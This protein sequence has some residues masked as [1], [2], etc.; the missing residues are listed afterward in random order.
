MTSQTPVT[1]SRRKF[2]RVAG[3]AGTALIGGVLAGRPGWA[4]TVT[5]A[6]QSIETPTLTIAYEMSGIGRQGFPAVLLH[7]FPDDVRAWDEVVTPLAQAGYRVLTFEAMEKQ[8]AQRP[9]V[10]V[11]SILLYGASDPLA[12]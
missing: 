2:L 4:Q 11:P 10:Q 12:R 3:L 1:K 8:L 5:P 9:K 7:G 6:T